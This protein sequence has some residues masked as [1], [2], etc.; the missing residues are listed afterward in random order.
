MDMTVRGFFDGHCTK[1]GARIGWAGT[2]ADRP[3]CHAC[4]FQQDPKELA[5]AQKAMDDARKAMTKA[6]EARAKE[7]DD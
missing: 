5:A 3:P 7:P 2:V 1:C 4:G 6:I